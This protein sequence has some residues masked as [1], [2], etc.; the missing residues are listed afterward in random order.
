[1][2]CRFTALTTACLLLLVPVLSAQN[3]PATVASTALAA[4]ATGSEVADKNSQQARAVLDAMVKALGGDAWLHQKNS[5]RKGHIAAFY[6]GRA[7]VG[8]TDY[9]EFHQWPAHDRLEITKHRDVLQMYVGDKG[10]EV[11]YRGKKPLPEDV[12]QDYLR[13]RDHSM[14]TALKVWLQDPNT[15][16]LYEGKQMSGRH[17]CD[18]VTLISAANQSTTLLADQDTHLPLRRIFQWRDPVYKDK[19]SDAE[20]YDDYHTFQGFPT[21]MRITRYK[22]DDMFRQYYI[23]HIEYEVQLADDFWDVDAATRRIKK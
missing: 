1:M 6:Q 4:T 20:E 10:W 19:N 21:A 12:Q 5:M 8:T 22:N 3:G 7:D 18:Q 13:R 2:A 14:E 11:T 17:L 15:I 9:W 23:D 16:L